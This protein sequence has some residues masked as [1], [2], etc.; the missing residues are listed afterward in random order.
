[1]TQSITQLS[2]NFK[3]IITGNPADSCWLFKTIT[4]PVNA[5]SFLPETYNLHIGYL[6][7]IQKGNGEVVP[8]NEVNLKTLLADDKPAMQLVEDKRYF[9]AIQLYNKNN[10]KKDKHKEL[11]QR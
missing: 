2:G 5:Y 4:G 8:L 10:K 11:S 7:M 3:D 1:M 6:K 9:E